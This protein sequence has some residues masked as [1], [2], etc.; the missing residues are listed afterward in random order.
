MPSRSAK[1]LRDWKIE[2]IPGHWEGDVLSG[3]KNSD[4]ATLRKHQ[5]SRQP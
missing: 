5:L 4:M 3:A 2:A 1:G